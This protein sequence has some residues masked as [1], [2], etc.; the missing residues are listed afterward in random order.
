[1]AESTTKGPQATAKDA[2][3][4]TTTATTADSPGAAE[5]AQTDP[6]VPV[7]ITTDALAVEE[8]RIPL[9]PRV[10]H[11]P[12]WSSVNSLLCATDE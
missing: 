12:R 2:T 8:V 5:R 4:V 3:E 7:T 6:S 11:W 9:T 10:D 1:M